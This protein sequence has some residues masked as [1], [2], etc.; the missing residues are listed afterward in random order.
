MTAKHSAAKTTTDSFFIL[1]LPG[2]HLTTYTNAN[3]TILFLA[4]QPVRPSSMIS[5][6]PVERS[7]FALSIDG[8]D[9]AIDAAI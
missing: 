5:F 7:G 8:P 3:L 6:A 9:G 1:D 2:G 4:P